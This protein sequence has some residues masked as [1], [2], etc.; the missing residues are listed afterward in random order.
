[1]STLDPQEPAAIEPLE[2]KLS[3]LIIGEPSFNDSGQNAVF[4]MLTGFRSHIP[5]VSR[6]IE[7][8][9][10]LTNGPRMATQLRSFCEK[11]RRTSTNPKTSGLFGVGLFFRTEKDMALA[12]YF[13]NCVLLHE[14]EETGPNVPV[15]E[16]IIHVKY[17]NKV[18]ITAK[19]QSKVHIASAGDMPRTPPGGGRIIT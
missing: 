16:D 17:E 7:I 4:G 13:E 15:A 8:R 1:M 5:N 18:D 11:L 9:R 10:V 3:L 14:Y 2:P 19:V 6:G 12:L